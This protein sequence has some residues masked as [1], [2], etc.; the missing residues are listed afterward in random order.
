[1]DVKRFLNKF[2]RNY[3]MLYDGGDEDPRYRELVKVATELM[4]EVSEQYP[5][6]LDAIVAERGDWFM[7]DREI[8][9]FGLTYS[10]MVIEDLFS[11]G[12]LN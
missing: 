5:E 3:E 4:K 10:D 11:T 6:D 2:N 12:D 8:A 1:M 9:A 7:S